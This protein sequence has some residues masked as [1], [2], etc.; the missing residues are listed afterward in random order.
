MSARLGQVING[1]TDCCSTRA[2]PDDNVNL[3]TAYTD[4]ITTYPTDVFEGMPGR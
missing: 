1:K 2:G 3:S 4:N